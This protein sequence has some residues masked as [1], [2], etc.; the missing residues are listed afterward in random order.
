MHLDVTPAVLLY[1][2][3]LRV[4]QIFDC[5]PK[6]PDHVEANPEGFALWFDN[7]VLPNTILAERA[8]L[9][10][11]DV[12]PVPTQKPLTH[13]PPKLIA[14]QLIKRWRDLLYASGRR[15]ER[16]PP[17]ILLAKLIAD[18]NCPAVGLHAT[19]TTVAANLAR[20]MKGPLLNV[21]NP[22]WPND[23][24]TDRWPRD[25][26]AQHQFGI[27]LT[28]LVGRLADLKSGGSVEDKFAPM[29]ALFGERVTKDGIKSFGK[30]MANQSTTGGLRVGPSGLL[31]AAPAAS[32][33]VV[34]KHHSYGEDW[35]R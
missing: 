9:A 21:P 17:S 32:G 23:N 28:D 3:P 26:N 15:A 5:H 14:L 2:N 31:S 25:L 30:R 11:A 13:K 35:W 8:L 34:P 16:K 18:T 22:A 4:S 1:D 20:I 33:L 24:L 27:E 12:K 29:S 7:A 10:K 19:M 6:R